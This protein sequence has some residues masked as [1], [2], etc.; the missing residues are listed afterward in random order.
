LA[1]TTQIVAAV[2]GSSRQQ[3][4]ASRWALASTS[5]PRQAISQRPCERV[6]V[7]AR[8]VEIGDGQ[9]ELRLFYF[10]Q[11]FAPALGSCNLVGIVA[12]LQDMALHKKHRLVVIND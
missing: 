7:H 8:H 9:V 3:Y 1:T 5:A 10:L 4:T 12:R 2:N 11:G 6:A